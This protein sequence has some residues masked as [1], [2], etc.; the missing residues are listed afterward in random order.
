L[1]GLAAPVPGK[2]LFAPDPYY[3][4]FEYY[5]EQL[6]GT[7]GLMHDY[8][9]L[10]E[11]KLG[12]RLMR[13]KMD[14]F[15]QILSLARARHPAVVNAVT[16]TP[17]RSGFLDFTEPLVEI[18]NVILVR[19]DQAPV[20]DLDNLEGRKVAMVQDYAITEYVLGKYP[21]IQ[22]ETAAIDLLALLAVSYSLAD[23]AIIDLASAYLHTG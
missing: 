2:L 19:K 3:A 23:A 6:G 9:K 21:G 7:T 22:V 4:P 20:V 15:E 10:V 12:I 5:D 8:L 1:A 16:K 11:E 13:V 17:E 18:D 14:S